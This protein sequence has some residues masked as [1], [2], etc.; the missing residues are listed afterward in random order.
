MVS[1][2]HPD[3]HDLW[4]G[5]L[6]PTAPPNA[7][8]DPRPYNIFNAPPAHSYAGPT[9]N[10]RFAS[11]DL[12]GLSGAGTPSSL[13]DEYELHFGAHPTIGAAAPSPPSPPPLEFDEIINLLAFVP[14]ETT[15][16]TLLQ[17]SAGPTPDRSAPIQ[18]PRPAPIQIPTFSQAS[19]SSFEGPPMSA[20]FPYSMYSRPPPM[21]SDVQRARSHSYGGPI[22]GPYAS[23]AHPSVFHSPSNTGFSGTF[24]VEFQDMTPGPSRLASSRPGPA[25][26]IIQFDLDNHPPEDTPFP[27]TIQSASTPL[28]G[29]PSEESSFMSSPTLSPASS[30]SSLANPPSPTTSRA[31]TFRWRL[32]SQESQGWRCDCKT[33]AKKK[34]RHLESC[35][36]NPNKPTIKCPCCSQIF[37]GGSRKSALKKHMLNFHKDRLYMLKGYKG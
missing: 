33:T 1:S 10:D 9:F 8:D 3:E 37:I 14:N 5:D 12:S 26:H 6:P 17:G 2:N 18:A 32:N 29:S 24:H 36:K 34:K 30:T 25:Q 16:S 11:Q 28:P 35:P 22:P 23:S 13:R 19:H 15:G 7:N 4:A 21:F 27:G 31:E 20:S